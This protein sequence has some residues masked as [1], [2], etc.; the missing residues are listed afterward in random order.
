MCECECVCTYR[1]VDGHVVGGVATG[2]GEKR[3]GSAHNTEGDGAI[4][5]GDNYSI[6]VDHLGPHEGDVDAIEI[7]GRACSCG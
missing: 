7:Q 6:F 1:R 2:G 5:G 3:P 4:G